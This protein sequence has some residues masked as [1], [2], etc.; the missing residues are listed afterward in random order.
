MT[1]E[2]RIM[3][4]S[5][6]PADGF[7]LTALYALPDHEV[8]SSLIPGIASRY[9]GTDDAIAAIHAAP[10]MIPVAIDPEVDS[11]GGGKV[12]WADIGDYPYR[13]W[14]HIF[15]IST[16]AEQGALGASFVTDFAI[17]QDDRILADPIEPSGFM[18]HI[19]RCGSTLTGKAL[20]RSPRH[21][22][23]NQGAP[24]QRGFWATITRDWAE[25]AVP[26]AENL[27]AFRNLVL[28]M[29]RRR[30]A[31]EE[32]AFIKFISWNTLYMDFALAAF[33]QV[34]ALFLY[35]DPVEVIA[36]VL[37]ET[38]AVVWA[39]G[40]RQAGFLSGHDW[41]ATAAMDE[42]EYLA[43]CFARYLRFAAQMDGRA[44]LVNYTDIKPEKFADML[45]RGLDFR[46]D[47]DQL[48][49]M[50]EQFNFHSKDDNNQQQFTSDSAQK[51]AS[52]SE[53]DR[54]RVAEIC[55]D[56]LTQL[57]FS[58]ANLFPRAQALA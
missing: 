50:L 45:D 9:L 32:R 57:D 36:S 22:V 42:I 23:I 48:A 20:A 30:F 10:G 37:R 53:T 16:L 27:R 4:P 38:S 44:A 34:P 40:R 25:D 43:H 21:L 54:R 2:L 1:A 12:L 6:W 55:G 5:R 47:A 7:S 24:L 39:K 52:I 58:P 31:R 19:S 11:G 33:P 26:S 17:L 18:F 46:P 51:R 56:A 13:E 29:T 15:T 3:Q 49:L 28:A 8:V 41:R 14:Q 35:R